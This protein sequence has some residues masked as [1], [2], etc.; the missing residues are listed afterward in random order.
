MGSFGGHKDDRGCSLSAG[1]YQQTD[2]H[3]PALAGTNRTPC[4]TKRRRDG[5]R[6]HLLKTAESTGGLQTHGT[7]NAHFGRRRKSS[8]STC[9]WQVWRLSQQRPTDPCRPLVYSSNPRTAVSSCSWG[10]SGAGVWG[11]GFKPSRLALSECSISSTHCWADRPQHFTFATSRRTNSGV[12]ERLCCK[13]PMIQTGNYHHL[14]KQHMKH[15]P[16]RSKITQIPLRFI[17]N[18]RLYQAHVDEIQRW[19]ACCCT[20]P[21]VGLN[22]VSVLHFNFGLRQIAGNGNS[23]Q[24]SSPP[25]RVVGTK[26]PSKSDKMQAQDAHSQHPPEPL[27]VPR[28]CGVPLSRASS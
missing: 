4:Q 10:G 11:Q 5:A 23:P 28:G 9:F 16:Q 14:S 26:G 3:T 18:N 7:S 13:R 21:L 19:Q 8:S 22:G 20:L 6:G 2:P 24:N 25:F 12:A 27:N 17:L 1:K 15:R